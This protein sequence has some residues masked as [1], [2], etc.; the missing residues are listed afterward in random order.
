VE[1]SARSRKFGKT[2]LLTRTIMLFVLV[3]A[4]RI[5]GEGQVLHGPNIL[6]S[7]DGNHPQTEPAIAADPSDE[8]RLVGAAIV[9]GRTNAGFACRVFSSSDGGY[10]WTSSSVPEQEKFGGAD[11]QT[12]FGIHGTAYFAAIAAGA[13]DQP[14]SVY[15]YRSEDGG[16]TWDKG[17]DLGAGDHDEM[18]VDL[19]VGRYAGRVYMAMEKTVNRQLGIYVF[20]SNDD[21]RSFA[22]PV[23]AARHEGMGVNAANL[24]LFSDGALFVPFVTFATDAAKASNVRG[25][26]FAISNDGGITF[27]GPKHILDY[28]YPEHAK[29]YQEYRSGSVVQYTFP[30]FA[31]DHSESSFRDRLYM[32]WSDVEQGRP[33][34]LFAF[35]SDRGQHWSQPHE[36]RASTAGDSA[37]FQQAVT[38]S[39]DG[40][41]GVIWFEAQDRKQANSFD[42]YFAVSR[43]GGANFSQPVKISS[44][45]SFPLHNANLAPFA[46]PEK[47]Q[48]SV[49]LYFLSPMNR[50]NGGGDYIGLAAD[51]KGVFHP[52]WP[53]ARAGVYQIYTTRVDVAHPEDS[54]PDQSSKTAVNLTSRIALVFDPVVYDEVSRNLTLPVRIK[55]LSQQT[56]YGPIRVELRSLSP[57][58]LSEADREDVGNIPEI[59]NAGNGERGAGAWFDYSR[60]LGTAGA[61]PPGAIS[62]AVQWKLRLQRPF[63][64]SFYVDAIVNGF[65]AQ[66]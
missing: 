36:M 23:L 5:I 45:T 1:K 14:T 61:L 44:A 22:G 52:F 8:R 4:I 48:D 9:S 56:L 19:S 46:M 34:V 49:A 37:A 65:V 64:T 47:G 26:E 3:W 42:V 59:L 12:A 17:V 66:K 11:P 43:D 24:Q 21:G 39:K 27:T 29:L 54:A 16:R 63:F 15:F 53:D 50:W 2:V 58:G 57:P 18:V 25:L 31:I 62:D 6:V 7:P 30:E 10:T 41:V 33:R 40:A 51:A 35:S 32:A 13:L 38:V 28:H 20:R 55:N 60:S